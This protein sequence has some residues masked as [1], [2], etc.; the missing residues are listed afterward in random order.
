M[1]AN[2][3][4]N[5]GSQ[6]ADALEYNSLSKMPDLE[7]TALF[8]VRDIFTYVA[9]FG[10]IEN[11]ASKTAIFTIMAD[12]NFL[13]QQG[14]FFASLAGA[15]QTDA[16]RVIPLCNVTITD[17]GSGRQLMSAPVAVPSLFGYGS[18]PFDLPTPRFFRANSQISVQ[19][20]NFSA[21]SDYSLQL[22]FIGTKFFKF[23]Q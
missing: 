7:L 1:D 8:G 5:I 9:D 22:H 11:G 3:G 17:T 12:S 10:E 2:N 6:I 19:V 14:C 18:L 4:I 21:E 16:S 23:Q 15:V 20:A 13:W